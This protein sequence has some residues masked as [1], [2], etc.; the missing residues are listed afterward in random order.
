MQKHVLVRSLQAFVVIPILA[1]NFST[2]LLGLGKLPTVVV[3]STVQN[4]PQIQELADNHQLE[5]EEM[6]HKIDNY[7]YDKHV[8]LA[9]HGMKLVTEADKNG[10]PLT[11]VASMG[12]IESTG[13]K[14]IIPSTHNCFGW[15]S[16]KIHFDSVDHAIEVISWNLGGHNPNTAKHYKGKELEDI[17]L[18]YNPPEADPQYKA[19]ILGVMNAI[20]SYEAKTI[21]ATNM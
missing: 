2:V 15:G 14:F 21:V 16:G 17:I 11:L 8:P 18:T 13:C 12:F 20:E 6:A 9:G 19:K 5:L 3:P 1:T 10:I 4:G 7:F